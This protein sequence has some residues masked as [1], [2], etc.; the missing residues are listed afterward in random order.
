MKKLLHSLLL[1]GATSSLQAQHIEFPLDTN[2][3]TI[4]GVMNASEW[5]NAET[6]LINVNTAETVQVMFKH[7]NNAMYFAYS[8]KLESANALFPE[9]LLDPQN[10]G[11]NSW[12]NGQWWFHVS[13]TDCEDST[14]YGIYNNCM[15]VQPDW[16]GAPN[17]TMGAPM[18]DT[19]EIR[20]PFS[21]VGFSTATMDT[22][23]IS[24]MVTNTVSAYHLYPTTADRNMPNT[25]AKATFSKVYAGISSLQ[26][27]PLPII[28]PNPVKNE[29]HVD[30]R[31]A[32]GDMTITDI[33]GAVQYHSD[34]IK[35]RITIPVAHLAAGTYLVHIMSEQ[36]QF[37]KLFIKQ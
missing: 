32:T 11:G 37:T 13:A 23:G 29:L 18:T 30:M 2:T 4:D 5:Q 25:W 10:I 31:N 35:G 14:N 16:Q 1:I 20:I 15:A 7:D 8:G 36:S 27:K 21:K 3:V 28:F 34:D 9:V 33:T 6:I 17:F 22:M 19:V 24:M 26:E 12:S